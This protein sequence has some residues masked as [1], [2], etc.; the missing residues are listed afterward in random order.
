MKWKHAALEIGWNT[1]TKM[2]VIVFYVIPELVL[3]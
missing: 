2:H 1:L 3:F